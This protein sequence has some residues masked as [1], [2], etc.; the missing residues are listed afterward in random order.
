MN[1]ANVVCRQ[2]GF[3]KATQAFHSA[4]HG[5]GTG[6]I[7]MDDVACSGSESHIY[8]CR[9]RGWGDNDCTHS[10]DA[11]VSCFPIRLVGG[12]AHGR[13][14]VFYKGIWAQCATMAGIS[15]MPTW[16][17]VSLVSPVQPPPL[18]VQNTVRD[19]ILS[20]WM[21]SVAK[22]EMLHCLTARMRGGEWRIAAMARTQ[23][24]FV[25]LISWL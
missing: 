24:W 13:V 23:V 11:G 20:G 16:C 8:D 12:G 15:M 6:P 4:H 14:E 22:V 5:Q 25:T 18:E 1:D 19:L 2:L 17:V 21:M 3:P 10:E 7:W 9:Q